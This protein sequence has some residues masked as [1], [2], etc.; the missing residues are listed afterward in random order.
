MNDFT[1]NKLDMASQQGYELKYNELRIGNI[2]WL[3]SKSKE[4]EI[5]SGQEID[6]GCDSNDF[7]PI[8]LTEEWLVRL[9]FVSDP[10]HDMYRKGFLMLNCDK[11]RGKLE[12]WPDNITGKVLYLKHVNQLQNLYFA[13]TGEELELKKS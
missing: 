12:L 7:K 9:G 11:T 5:L 4:W 2:V 6:T 3:V 1:K 10:Y 8:P 13:I